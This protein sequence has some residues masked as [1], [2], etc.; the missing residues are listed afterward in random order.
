MA[1]TPQT[2]DS[3][4]SFSAY[5]DENGQAMGQDSPTDVARPDDLQRILDGDPSGE[6]E[7]ARVASG[8]KSE[9]ATEETEAEV[10]SETIDKLSNPH[11]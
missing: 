10:P 9:D 8:H 7:T 11:I 4:K 5:R 2:K 6:A 1:D 3:L